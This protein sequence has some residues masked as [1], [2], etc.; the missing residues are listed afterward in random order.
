MK[1]A[2]SKFM[3]I[4]CRIIVGRKDKFVC[5]INVRS[6]VGKLLLILLSKGCNIRNILPGSRRFFPVMVPY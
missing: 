2:F 3:D 6:N 1:K 4:V 5:R